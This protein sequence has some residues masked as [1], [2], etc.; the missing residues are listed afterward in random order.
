MSEIGLFDHP[1]MLFL[2]RTLA[3]PPFDTL[4]PAR[5]GLFL[6]YGDRAIL[7][8]GPLIVAR[9]VAL[10]SEPLLYLDG[11]NTFDPYPIV[12]AA[13]RAG[14]NPD[15]VLRSI[16][17]SRAFTCHQMEAL[18]VRELPRAVRHH[19]PEAA[20]LAGLLETFYD[21]NVPSSETACLLQHALRRLTQMA[22]DGARILI[23][24]A[25]PPKPVDGRGGMT[26]LIRARADRAFRA[27]R[28]E[29]RLIVE[30]ERTRQIGRLGSERINHES[31]G[32]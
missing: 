6:L 22:A 8:L 19:R 9:R 7:R 32:L 2:E 24:S 16:Y 26:D 29:E 14:K 28:E 17:V 4:K 20:I 13:R 12:G 10:S 1:D 21:E 25:D 3:L 18:I 31:A 23:L 27:R 15:A 11:A 5:G 30:E